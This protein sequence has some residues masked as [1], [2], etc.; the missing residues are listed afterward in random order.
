MLTPRELKMIFDQ[1]G[2]N[3]M[4]ALRVDT[5]TSVNTE[6]IIKWSYDIQAGSYIE[7]QKNPGVAEEKR[8]YTEEIARLL[9]SVGPSQ[10]IAEAGVGEA[11]TLSGVMQ[12]MNLPGTYFYGF[13]LSW[14]RVAFAQALLKQRAAERVSLCMASLFHIPYAS[15]SIDIVYTSHS[16]EPNG[17]KEEPILRE[18]YRVARKY[19]ILLEPGY[20][21]ADA[22][23]R[24]R[25]EAHGYCRDLVNIA[26]RLG[27]KVVEHRRFSYCVNPSITTAVTV[28]EKVDELPRPAEVLACPCFKTPLMEVGG[29]LYSPEALTVYPVI[30][31]VACLHIEN[32]IVACH[33]PKFCGSS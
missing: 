13:D 8:L 3:L 27:Y 6:E 28:I 9:L 23:E 5:A 31:G 16:I 20:E 15:D 14:S 26:K 25:M 33:Y 2:Q 12:N 4:Q 32:G 29:M 19:L 30:G 7:A 11:T 24:S 1:G 10:S 21:I 17:G 18:L 22:E